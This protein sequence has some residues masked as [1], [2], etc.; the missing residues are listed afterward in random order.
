M[1]SKINQRVNFCRDSSSNA[2]SGKALSENDILS[3]LPANEEQKSGSLYNL[4]LESIDNFFGSHNL[5]VKLPTD[6]TTEI[7]RS[8]DEGKEFKLTYFTKH[9]LI[10]F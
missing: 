7:A 1:K 3:A 4:F 2:R 5:V 6:T 9:L 8:F 10:I